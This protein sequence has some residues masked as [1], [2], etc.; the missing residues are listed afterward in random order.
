M[1][2]RPTRPS[3]SRKMHSPLPSPRSTALCSS[4]ASTPRSAI[5]FATSTRSE[6]R[7]ANT[8][9]IQFVTCSLSRSP[10]FC[11]TRIRAVFRDRPMRDTSG[12]SLAP[13]GVAVIAHASSRKI[14]LGSRRSIPFRSLRANWDTRYSKATDSRCS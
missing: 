6:E 5:T 9:D 13:C 2:I 7:N 4:D 12:T 3:R 14:A 10:A 1:P 11:D 8:P